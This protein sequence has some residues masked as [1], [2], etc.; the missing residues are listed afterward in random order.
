VVASAGLRV[1][2]CALAF[3]AAACGNSR[4]ATDR[5]ELLSVLRRTAP[6]SKSL[7]YVDQASERA[8]RV[9]A[10]VE[11]G[12]RYSAAASMDG[13]PA[14]SVVVSDDAI[15]FRADPS[16]TGELPGPG[17]AAGSEWVID[18]AGAPPAIVPAKERFPAGANPVVDAL[19]VLDYAEQASRQAL[20][21]V[22]FNPDDIEYR[23]AEDPFPTPGP[24]SGVT[25]FDFR[26]PNLPSVSELGGA[27]QAVPGVEHFRKMSVYVRDGR[28]VAVRED[29]DVA[30]RLADLSRIYGVKFPAE[31][32]RYRLVQIA[33]DSLNALRQGQGTD[34]IRVRRMSA[35]FREIG[36]RHQVVMPQGTP[37]SLAFLRSP[38]P[39]R[40]V[41]SS[42]P[43]GAGELDQTLASAGIGGGTPPP[44][45]P[46]AIDLGV[47]GT[48]G[49]EARRAVREERPPGVAVLMWLGALPLALCVTG[50]LVFRLR[51]AGL[52][53]PR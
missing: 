12:F 48:Q 10:T 49:R 7:T 13:S 16:F 4:A 15:A 5:D 51:K 32:D 28:V 18:R 34:P 8:V 50:G 33:V 11:D 37:G 23:P 42:R 30:G 31:L 36:R 25:R 47:L 9:D 6:L 21:V 14:Y 38:E 40:A 43:D 44:A 27:N 26:R 53:L 52:G 41:P 22:K 39:P 1:L 46:G 35:V 45:S 3:A 20:A 17:A 24:R 19:L 29:I 2:A